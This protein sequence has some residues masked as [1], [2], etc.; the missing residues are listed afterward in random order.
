M[1][2]RGLVRPAS[3]SDRAIDSLWSLF[4]RPIIDHPPMVGLDTQRMN[5]RPQVPLILLNKDDLKH[6]PG[7][8][9]PVSLLISFH[10]VLN[11]DTSS[12]GN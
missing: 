8:Q 11:L 3:D 2:L 4:D 1:L 10:F 12:V 5:L 6:G 9:G 7:P